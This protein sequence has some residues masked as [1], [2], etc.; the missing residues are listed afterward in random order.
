MFVKFTISEIGATPGLLKREL[1]NILRECWFAVGTHWLL[2]FRPKHF[3]RAG[4]REYG[5][6]PRKPDYEARKKRAAMT[7]NIKLRKASGTW[8]SGSRARGEPEP[9]VWSGQSREDTKFGRV[10]AT[11][12]GVRI[13]MNAPRLNWRNPNSRINPRD[14]LTRISDAEQKTLM[15]VFQEKFDSLVARMRNI[16]RKA[17]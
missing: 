16:R 15:S 3:T 1:N 2:K 10:S 4:A 9:L 5:Y 13:T 17:A 7:A 8:V 11:K 12:N 6:T 14:E